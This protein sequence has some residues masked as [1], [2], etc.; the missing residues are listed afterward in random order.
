MVRHG[1]LNPDHASSILAP[2]TETVAQLVERLL[3]EQV[4]MGSNPTSLPMFA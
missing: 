2:R 1:I 4:V 3:V